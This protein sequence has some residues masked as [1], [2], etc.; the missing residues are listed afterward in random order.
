MADD[1]VAR[2]RALIGTR[3]VLH[4][5][6]AEGVDC[7][8]LVAAAI[9]ARDVPTGYALRSTEVRAIERQCKAFGLAP[10]PALQA[11]DVA[12]M[13]AGPAQFH[14]GIWTGVSLIHAEAS[15]RRVVES[16]G[17]IRWPILSIWRH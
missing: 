8:G 9:G 12:V 13:R 17:P 5:R 16:P 14:F 6:D 10:A 15:L 11:G 2:A 1:I 3:F 7:I 4:G